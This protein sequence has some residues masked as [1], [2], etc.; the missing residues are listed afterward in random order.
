MVFRNQCLPLSSLIS[1]RTEGRGR[2]LA[3]SSMRLTSPNSFLCQ[4]SCS[5]DQPS[6]VP[7]NRLAT[8]GMRLGPVWTNLLCIPQILPH[9][10]Q[11]SLAV[12]LFCG[13]TAFRRDIECW[14]QAYLI[15]P[16]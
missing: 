12:S 7:C 9:L 5:V 10:R 13:V 6:S 1:R 14:I 8:G 4:S 15:E 2:M 16:V 11:S 3:E